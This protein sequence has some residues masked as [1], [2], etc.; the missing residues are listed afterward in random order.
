MYERQA[1]MTYTCEEK[2]KH[3]SSCTNEKWVGDLGVQMSGRVLI[4]GAGWWLLRINV[5]S[6][7]GQ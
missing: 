3:R 6:K 5:A 2:G 1:G 7:Y 4:I